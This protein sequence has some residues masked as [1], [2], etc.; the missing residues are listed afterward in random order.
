MCVSGK[1]AG[2]EHTHLTEAAGGGSCLSF[3]AHEEHAHYLIE[4][5]GV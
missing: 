5:V 2:A 3:F 1:Y 4:N